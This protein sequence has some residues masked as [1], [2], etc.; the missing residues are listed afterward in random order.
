[1]FVSPQIAG[2]IIPTADCVY[3]FNELQVGFPVE[4][5]VHSSW[6]FFPWHRFYLYF[7]ERILGKLLGDDTFALPFWN[8]DSPQGMS[9]PTIYATHPALRD[10]H[11]DPKHQPPALLT[12]DY[13]LVDPDDEVSSN[14]LISDNLTIMYRQLVSNGKT[15]A[16]FLGSPYH[17]GDDPNPG[18]GSVENIPHQPVHLWVGDRSQPNVEDMGTFYSAARD[19]IFFAH[20]GNIDRMWAIWKGLNR[21]DFDDPDWLNAAFLF[22]DENAELVRVKVADCLDTT[23]LR[24]AYEEVDLPWLQAKPKASTKTPTNISKTVDA[25]GSDPRTLTSTIRASVKRSKWSRTEKEKEEEEE[26]L[27]IQGIEVRRDVFVKFDICVNL[28]IDGE[29]NAVG[30]GS[31]KFA[32]SFTNL[33]HNYS[34]TDGDGKAMKLKTSLKLGLT[35]LLEDIGADG[36]EEIE[37]SLIMKAGN[38]EDITIGGIRIEFGS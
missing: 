34:E 25:F 36:D 35:D 21:K 5:Q 29:E 2:P 22:Y 16:L 28:N 7:H 1:M 6:L 11:R 38:G 8:W 9:L 23:K 33:P 24:Y 18:A 26:I 32:G 14:Q 27:V 10:E 37:V 13:N 30:P 20:H 31:H 12:L 17:A 3:F 4:I 15:A 19:P